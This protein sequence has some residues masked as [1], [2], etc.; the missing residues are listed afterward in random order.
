MPITHAINLADG[1]TIS[2]QT[3]FFAPQADGSVL[4]TMGKTMLLATAVERQEK[5]PGDFLPLS[6]DYKENFSA[7]GKI[8]GGFIKREGRLNESEILVSRLIDRSIRP[9]FAKDFFN[10]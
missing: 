3:D 5:V 6:V 9:C 2:L 1:R 10:I 4:L 7:A 8:R